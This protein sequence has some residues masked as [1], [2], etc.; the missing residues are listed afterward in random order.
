MGLSLYPLIVLQDLWDRTSS[1]K[2]ITAE[3]KEVV[4]ALHSWGAKS[5][6]LCHKLHLILNYSHSLTEKA[7][8]KKSFI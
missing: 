3:R 8:E 1:L 7:K 5:E 6:K 2:S 4:G